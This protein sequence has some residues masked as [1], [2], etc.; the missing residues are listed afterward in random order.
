MGR[1]ENPAEV[2]DNGVETPIDIHRREVVAYHRSIRLK[3]GAKY[4]VATRWE[5]R[6]KTYENSHHPLPIPDFSGLV[7]AT[8]EWRRWIVLAPDGIQRSV[9]EVPRISDHSKPEAGEL[10][11]PRYLEGDPPHIMYGEGSDGDRD[12]C[13]F[14]F[15]M[16]TCKLLR[17]QLVGRHW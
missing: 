1:I 2:W 15:D 11:E 3:T 17:V 7:Y 12:D 10:G 9:I 16:H 5:F 14:F 4:I 6:G 13:R 8:D